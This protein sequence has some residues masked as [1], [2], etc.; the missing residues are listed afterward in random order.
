[1][2]HCP[3][4]SNLLLKLQGKAGSKY[5]TIGKA[6]VSEPF[7]VALDVSL[8]ITPLQRRP[9]SNILANLELAPLVLS[10][11][12]ADS[13]PGDPKTATSLSTTQLAPSYSTGSNQTSQVS[14]ATR[15]SSAS[16]VLT[17]MRPVPGAEARSNCSSDVSVCRNQLLHSLAWT[18]EPCALPA[19]AHTPSQC[20]HRYLIM[21]PVFM[22]RQS[23]L[24][25]VHPS[26]P[27][28]CPKHF[29]CP[30]LD[31]LSL[32]ICALLPPLC[33]TTCR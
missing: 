32:S 24:L 19:R 21:L 29:V 31:V 3:D 9:V 14:Q 28:I 2:A 4:I 10:N 22:F 13:H 23:S 7:M 16:A 5:F 26:R 17:V 6:H 1:M 15:P 18:S 12:I 25:K 8:M 30:V 27:M 11:K 20:L 33:Q